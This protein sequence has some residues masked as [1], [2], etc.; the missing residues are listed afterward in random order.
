MRALLIHLV[1]VVI[2]SNLPIFPALLLSLLGLRHY[3]S[4]RCLHFLG[5]Q[6]LFREHEVVSI[7]ALVNVLVLLRLGHVQ[8]QGRFF[9]TADGREQASCEGVL[10]LH[11]V[12]LI[13]LGGHH[14]P[15]L[16]IKCRSKLFVGVTLAL[17]FDCPSTLDADDLRIADRPH[18][19]LLFEDF[20]PSV[21]R[22]APQ[23]EGLVS[24]QVRESSLSFGDLQMHVFFCFVLRL[25][26]WRL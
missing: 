10:S 14:V 23:L 26:L 20:V 16:V 6:P 22:G 18:V 11:R 13:A 5:Q 25:H 8:I 21:D 19:G 1:T 9:A 7:F 2:P 24:K 12:R 15:V 3:F 4:L 17:K